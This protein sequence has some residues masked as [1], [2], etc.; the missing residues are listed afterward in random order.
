MSQNWSQIFWHVQS[1]ILFSTKKKC[2]KKYVSTSLGILRISLFQ[3][4]E[5]KKFII[6]WTIFMSTIS[7]GE[8]H[9]VLPLHLF[10][11]WKNWYSRMGDIGLFYTKMLDLSELE[12]ELYSTT[13]WNIN[14]NITNNLTTSLLI[15]FQYFR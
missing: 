14:S 12:L 9:G 11:R 2:F 13:K 7:L 3:R 6:D 5:Y 4:F 15:P 1:Y 8:S 10:R